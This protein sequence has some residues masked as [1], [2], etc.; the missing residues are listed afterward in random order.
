MFCHAVLVVSNELPGNVSSGT[1][2][3][4][5]FYVADWVE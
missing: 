3:L 2:N 4:T 1:L 5:R